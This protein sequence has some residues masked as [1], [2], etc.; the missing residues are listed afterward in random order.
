MRFLHSVD[1]TF[2]TFVDDR[3][4]PKYAILSHTWGQDEV[5]YK[6]MKK[7]PDDAAKKQGY[8]KIKASAQRAREDGLEYFWVD[9]C[10]IDKS[11]SA[12]LSEAINSMY[13]LYQNSQVCYAFLSDVSTPSTHT[14][15][16]TWKAEFQSSR[17]FT[18]GWTLQELIAPKS[19]KFYSR[20]WSYIGTKVE[21]AV[22]ITEKT[23]IPQGV[24][25]SGDC[26]NSSV[27]QRMSWAAGRQTSRR[28]DEAYCLMG[29]FDV[30]MPMLYGEGRRAFLRLQEEILTKSDDLSIFSWVSPRMVF[31]SYRGLLAREVSEFAECSDIGW[32]R[33]TNNDPYQITNKGIHNSLPLTAREGRPGEFIALLRGVYKKPDMKIG[34]FLQSVGKEQYGRI[35][36]DQLALPQFHLPEEKT[37]LIKLFVR[38]N[39]VMEDASHNR[40]AGVSLIFDGSVMELLK[41]PPTASWNEEAKFFAF[42]GPIQS[43]KPPVFMCTLRS[44]GTQGDGITITVDAS[45]Q[46]GSVLGIEKGWNKAPAL[47]PFIHKFHCR[48][49]RHPVLEVNL[50]RGIFD[51]EAQLK[52][53]VKSLTVGNGPGTHA[54]RPRVPAGS[55][56]SWP[57]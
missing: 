38:Q 27:A 12:E 34:I 44:I 36:S 25:I 11:S 18:R 19:L 47:T 30:N 14:S 10:C 43:K 35:E 4:M 41:P 17:W 16:R 1:L 21:L 13:L 53:T 22:A 28:E 46:W 51:G 8:Q 42:E 7:R 49:P 23:A 24:I 45:N 6:E 20:S 40:V 48:R 56:R 9:T 26:S 57:H 33:G 32:V 52:L 15:D 2:N 3:D 39:V 50:E 55:S 29:I 37:S 5:T 54:I 31:S